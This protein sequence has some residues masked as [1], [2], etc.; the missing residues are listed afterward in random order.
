MENTVPVD[1]KMPAALRCMYCIKKNWNNYWWILK[2]KGTD[3]DFWVCWWLTR[4]WIITF[5]FC[6]WWR[7]VHILCPTK[8][9]LSGAVWHQKLIKK[10]SATRIGGGLKQA[11]KSNFLTNIIRDS[12]QIMSNKKQNFQTPSLL[13]ALKCIFTLDVNIENDY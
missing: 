11:E 2:I 3:G 5:V 8:G 10:I 4:I 6:S 12:S 7:I 9:P 1:M 13:C